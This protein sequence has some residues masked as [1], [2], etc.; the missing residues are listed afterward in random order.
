MMV[1]SVVGAMERLITSLEGLFGV[2]FHEARSLVQDLAHSPPADLMLRVVQASLRDLRERNAY[3]PYSASLIAPQVEQALESLDEVA[4]HQ[5]HDRSWLHRPLHS[6]RPDVAELRRQM[7]AL[8]AAADSAGKLV[9]I[10][11]VRRDQEH[12]PIRVVALGLAGNHHNHVPLPSTRERPS[13]GEQ[14]TEDHLN[15][16]LPKLPEGCP[17]A[18][19]LAR[20]MN[21]LDH[22]IRVSAEQEIRHLHERTYLAG[23]AVD[24]IAVDYAIAT[25]IDLVVTVLA[26]RELIVDGPNREAA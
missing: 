12:D 24:P 5:M 25:V 19:D 10:A 23:R 3:D 22:Q 7:L 14:R 16:W 4:E 8:T 2:P 13:G 20:V 15:T 1:S 26:V 21:W 6:L 11:L 17:D 9:R 18:K